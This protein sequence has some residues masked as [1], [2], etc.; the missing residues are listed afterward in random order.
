MKHRI[1][2]AIFLFISVTYYPIY[3]QEMNCVRGE[4][5]PVFSTKNTSVKTKTFMVV[6]SHEANEQV[7]FKSGDSLTI[8][9]WGCEYFILT[10]RYESKNFSPTA[11]PFLLASQALRN[12]VAMKAKTVF[13]FSKAVKSLTNRIKEDEELKLEEEYSVEGDGTDF[14][15]TKLSV[16]SAG[17]LLNGTGAYVEFNLSCGPL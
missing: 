5:K 11:N 10:F 9:N 13:G 17:H 7:L 8:R 6:S 1:I 2:T 15:Q 4:P 16:T 3:A 14:L 12:L